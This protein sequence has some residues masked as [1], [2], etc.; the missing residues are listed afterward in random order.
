MEVLATAPADS[1]ETFT[2][3]HSALSVRC[4]TVSVRC[5]TVKV[6]GC[7]AR[8][9]PRVRRVLSRKIA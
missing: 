7:V 5:A 9:S 1:A 4:A 2:R 3:S 6:A 8:P